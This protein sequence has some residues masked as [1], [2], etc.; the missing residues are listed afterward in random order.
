MFSAVVILQPCKILG[1]NSVILVL[2]RICSLVC[3]SHE[4]NEILRSFFFCRWPFLLFQWGRLR[5]SGGEDSNLQVRPFKPILNSGMTDQHIHP[6]L[7]CIPPMC[8]FV[9]VFIS[10]LSFFQETSCFLTSYAPLLL[11]P[12]PAAKTSL[13]L[14]PKRY[15]RKKRDLF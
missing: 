7:P 11:Y 2:S 10:E 12:R 9:T 4:G 14:P 8:P 6:P 13:Q 15:F 3:S 5:L 1:V